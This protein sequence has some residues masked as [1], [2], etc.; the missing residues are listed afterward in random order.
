M[1]LIQ[2]VLMKR[3]FSVNLLPKNVHIVVC[4]FLS[5]FLFNNDLGFSRLCALAVQKAENA[6]PKTLSAV[7]AIK[8]LQH[9]LLNIYKYNSSLR[10]TMR[11]QL[12]K[13]IL[14]QQSTKLI[15][16]LRSD[17]GDARN[18]VSFLLQILYSIIS[19]FIPL[20]SEGKEDD[21]EE[22]SN[23]NN[24]AFDPETLYFIRKE[25]LMEILIPLHLPN[26]M[27]VWRDQIPVISL[28]HEDLCRCTIQLIEKCQ[29]PESTSSSSSFIPFQGSLL[30]DVVKAILSNWPDA[31]NTNTPK[32]VLLLHE[33]E[34]LL[35]RCSPV[36]FAY[37]QIQFL[38]RKILSCFSFNFLMVD[39]LFFF[40]RIDSSVVSG[41]MRT[42]S[43]LLKEPC[44]FSR[45]I[46]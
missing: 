41:P 36:E 38:V 19:G 45:I 6:P 46:K 34:F 22:K 32:Q 3:N 43:D 44:S 16:D 7:Q 14:Q 17:C 24:E 35:E 5:C 15:P 26:E 28:F 31:Y 25:I 1:N 18:H 8:L 11:R 23:K 33:L 30:T 9:L 37:F 39:F 2:V 10:S 27:I 4:Y 21:E 40:F 12:T 42:T 20:S 13:A 29:R